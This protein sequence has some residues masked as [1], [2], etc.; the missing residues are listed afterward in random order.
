MLSLQVS[1][2]FD[3]A[4][5]AKTLLLNKACMQIPRLSL[6]ANTLIASRVENNGNE[7]KTCK[8]STFLS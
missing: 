1:E 8:V 5:C 2:R 7:I 3:F 4:F 6:R